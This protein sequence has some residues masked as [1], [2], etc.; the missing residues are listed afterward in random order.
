[1][2]VPFIDL[3]IQHKLIEPEL[4]TA[5]NAVLKRNDFIL[6][7]EVAFFER[8]FAKFCQVRYSIG[9]ASGTDGIFLALLALGIKKG[10]EVIVPD[11]TYI[12]TANAVSYSQAR[13]VFVD[14]DEKTYNIDIACL[15]KAITR[16]TKAVIPVHL[17]GQAANM[18]EIQKLA[19]KYGLKVIED[20]CQAHGTKVK[21]A[22]NQ[23]HRA[24]SLG[25]LA[26]FSFYP[27]KNLGGMGDAGIVTTNNDKLY[28]KILT[29]RDCGRVSKYDHRIIGYNSRLDTL[30]AA[31][32]RVKLKKI[33]LWNQLRR[34]SARIYDQLFK[35]TDITT[36][37]CADFSS[38]I[39]HA[40][41]IRVKD[42][43]DELLGYLKQKGIGSIVYYPIPLHLQGAYKN[44][45]YKKGDFPITEK[46]SKEVISL[47]IYPYITKK[48]IEYAVKTVKEFYQ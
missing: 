40:Y 1:M 28:K 6:G 25:D 32:L 33:A 17:F 5:I 46:L 43:R 18:T 8:E 4:Q 47:P 16:R 27:T 39:Y 35:N 37:F 34:E 9:V 20:A 15:K 45:N 42:R 11:F 10:D 3:E 26:S 13:T 24:G 30:Q 48:Q 12:A 36:P 14:V 2:K 44:L 41:V 21:L 29:L 7:Q 38:H 22:D 31:I 19:E 23:W